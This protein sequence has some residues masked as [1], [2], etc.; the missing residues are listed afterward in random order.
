MRLMTAH[1]ILIGA[2]VGFFGFLALWGL[3]QWF[4]AG[5]TATG[6]VAPA[7]SALAAT[8]LGLYYRRRFP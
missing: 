8:G 7:L 5:D 4:L 6:L 2:S 1:K 3:R